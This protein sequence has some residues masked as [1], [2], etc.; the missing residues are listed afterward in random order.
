MEK[1][2]NFRG[3]VRYSY[4][5]VRPTLASGVCKLLKRLVRRFR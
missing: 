3:I 4:A 1:G 2:M 5:P